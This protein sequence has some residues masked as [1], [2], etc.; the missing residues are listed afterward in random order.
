YRGLVETVD[1]TAEGAANVPLSRIR[2]VEKSDLQRNGVLAHV[3]GLDE[4]V[5]G[6]VP[7]VDVSSVAAFRSGLLVLDLNSILWTMEDASSQVLLD[8]TAWLASDLR[9][10]GACRTPGRD[11]LEAMIARRRFSHLSPNLL[12]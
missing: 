12:G 8:P 10:P 6:P 2:V 5:G 3:D 9:I 7:H 11:L 4:F 1:G